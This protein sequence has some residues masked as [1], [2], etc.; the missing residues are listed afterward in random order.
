MNVTSSNSLGKVYF[1]GLCWIEISQVTYMSC[2]GKVFE[3][4]TNKIQSFWGFKNL[5]RFWVF[6]LNYRANSKS[7]KQRKIQK[8]SFQW[9]INEWGAIIMGLNWPFRWKISI[10]INNCLVGNNER[11]LEQYFG[12]SRFSWVYV[13]LKFLKS[14]IHHI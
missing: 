12:K 3:R 10:W 6:V 11:H 8:I 13:E 4:L 14:F 9:Q 2:L 7:R 1:L 5:Q